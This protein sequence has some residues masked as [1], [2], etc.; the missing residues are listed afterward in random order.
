MSTNTTTTTRRKTRCTCSRV[1]KQL[2]DTL[3][4]DMESPQCQAMRAHVSQC[5]NCSAYLA[6]LK[7]T[8]ELYEFY[9][10]PALSP[11]AKAEL[12]RSVKAASKSR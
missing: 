4:A 10:L 8:V 5:A 6:S 2:C 12:L 7:R 1:F 9:P 11:R 3:G